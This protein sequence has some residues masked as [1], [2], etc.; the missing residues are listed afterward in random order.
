VQVGRLRRKLGDDSN[1][2]RAI[3]SVRGQGYLFALEVRKEG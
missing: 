1:P 3:K 2:P